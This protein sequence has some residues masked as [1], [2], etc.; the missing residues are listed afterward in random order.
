MKN[1][2]MIVNTSRGALIDSSGSTEALK[3]QKIVC[4][5]GRGLW[6]ERDLFFE[7]KLHWMRSRMTYSV[8]C[9]PATTC[10]LPGTRH[11]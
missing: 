9:L 10:C 6:N 3:N 4:W 1:G 2:V 8:A 7:D 11:S 5:Y